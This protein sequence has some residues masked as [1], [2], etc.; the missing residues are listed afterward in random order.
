M[1]SVSGGGYLGE[2][3]K[4]RKG[5]KGGKGRKGGKGLVR[6]IPLSTLRTIPT[7][8]AKIGYFCKTFEGNKDKSGV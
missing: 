6:F 1:W 3:E 7:F 4:G 8:L 5:A 2:G